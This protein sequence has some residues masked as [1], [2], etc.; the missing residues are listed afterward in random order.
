MYV[1]RIIT[2]RTCYLGLVF[3]PLKWELTY[4]DNKE[5]DRK[6]VELNRFNCVYLGENG[7][8]WICCIIICVHC[9]MWQMKM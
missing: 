4:M 7:N 1:K 2:V 5:N 3:L 8:S 6:Y 9:E